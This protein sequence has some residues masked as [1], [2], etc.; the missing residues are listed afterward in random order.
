MDP[1]KT[2]SA[3]VAF[4]YELIRDHVTPGAVELCMRNTIQPELRADR[5]PI[6]MIL[7][8]GYIAAYA[9]DI[10]ERLL[11]H[12]EHGEKESRK[13]ETESGYAN[14]YHDDECLFSVACAS[15]REAEKLADVVYRQQEK[16]NDWTF[17]K[18]A[19]KREPVPGAAPRRGDRGC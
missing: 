11:A 8:N 12:M 4:L 13:E 1:I 19:R 10:A 16:V 18:E 3:L 15:V 6:N 2:R 7:S 9:Q 5:A 14:F 17:T